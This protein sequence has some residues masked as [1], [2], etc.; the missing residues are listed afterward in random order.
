MSHCH[1]EHESHE[2]EDEHNHDGPD[3]GT[4][5]SLYSR[6]DRENVRCLNESSPGLGKNFVESDV[7][8]QLIL[9]IPFTGSVKLK[10]ISIKSGPGN[11]CPSKM[12]AYINREDI[13]FDT[14]DSYTA[15]QEWELISSPD[16]IEYVTRM[17]KMYNVRNLT[18]YFPEN[19]GDDITRIFYIGLKG[20]WTEIK[21]DQIITIYESTPNPADHKNPTED[22]RIHHTIN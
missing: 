17:T 14:V 2:H 20:E 13:D 6:I 19:F 11:S 15:T 18:L 1:D 3:R 7:D 4:E 16:N 5:T 9:F 21:S 22:E 12:K 8:E 10:S